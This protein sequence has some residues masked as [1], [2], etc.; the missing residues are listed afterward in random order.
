MSSNQ[1]DHSLIFASS[2]AQSAKLPG[3]DPTPIALSTGAI[4]QSPTHDEA[5]SEFSVASGGSSTAASV[6]V[7]D[8]PFKL[9]PPEDVSTRI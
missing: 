9:K 1:H 7:N 3:E 2:L 4:F 5:V 6:G 8:N